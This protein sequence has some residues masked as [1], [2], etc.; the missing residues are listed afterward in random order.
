MVGFGI[1][2]LF[3]P[4]GRIQSSNHFLP[5]LG[6]ITSILK[7]P[8]NFPVLQAKEH[9]PR[10]AHQAL[11]LWSHAPLLPHPPALPSPCSPLQ[12]TTVRHAP[13]MR[14]LSKSFWVNNLKLPKLSPLCDIVLTFLALCAPGYSKPYRRIQTIAHRPRVV[15]DSCECGAMQNI[16]T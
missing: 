15:K 8:K 7:N 3:P 10:G 1:P 6:F 2:L 4:Q 12:L 9:S 13:M 16:N 11:S 14:S 5:N